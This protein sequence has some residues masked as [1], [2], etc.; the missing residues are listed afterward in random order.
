MLRGQLVGLFLIGEPGMK[1]ALG[2]GFW[3]E[4]KLQHD[5][6]EKVSVP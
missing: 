5:S 2:L 4:S 6:V 3:G 1:T